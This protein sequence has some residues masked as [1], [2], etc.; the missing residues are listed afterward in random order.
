MISQ[1]S[2]VTQRMLKSHLVQMSIINISLLYY[3]DCCII[4]DLLCLAC[5]RRLHCVMI[6]VIM[7]ILPLWDV[8]IYIY[9]YIYIYLYIYIFIYLYIYIYIGVITKKKPTYNMF[10]LTIDKQSAITVTHLKV[11]NLKT[12]NH[13]VG[14]RG[15]ISDF[16]LI[17]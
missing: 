3:I 15:G 4:N 1:K 17:L 12:Y 16:S 8:Y 10:Q 9:I 5:A 7:F 11:S 6:T 14:L 2:S 13:T